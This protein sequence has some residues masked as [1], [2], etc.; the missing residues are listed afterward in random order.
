M[1]PQQLEERDYSYCQVF[2]S[3]RPLGER[4]QRFLVGTPHK[5]EALSRAEAY[6]TARWG[7][8]SSVYVY[9]RNYIR[10]ARDLFARGEH[11]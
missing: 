5:R 2:Y 8:P 11:D 7:P 4:V 1:T 6:A 10:R 9:P 3:D